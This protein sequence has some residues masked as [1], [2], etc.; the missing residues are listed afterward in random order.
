MEK[1]DLL[2]AVNANML[3]LRQDL[4]EHHRL[5]MAMLE[6][7]TPLP[8]AEPH[9]E[10]PHPGQREQKYKATI[11]QAIQTLEHS[12]KSFKSKQLGELRKQLMNVLIDT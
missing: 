10:R 12:R 6:G 1:K 4:D 3:S 8:A 7:D 9:Q 11:R 5:L 2:K